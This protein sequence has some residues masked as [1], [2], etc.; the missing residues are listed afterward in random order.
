MNR[1]NS[2]GL[3]QPPP[4]GQRTFLVNTL[5]RGGCLNEFLNRRPS[6]TRTWR[7]SAASLGA[8]TS[9]C[10]AMVT[11]SSLIQTPALAQLCP[12]DPDHACDQ[13][14]GPGCTNLECCEAVCE[15][16][17][18]CCSQAWDLNCVAATEDPLVARACANTGPCSIP[19]CPGGASAENEACGASTNGGCNEAVPVFEPIAN[20]DTVCGTGWADGG[21]RDTDWF[22]ITL[23]DPDG[24]DIDLITVD[25]ISQFPS[26]VII[27]DASDCENIVAFVTNLADPCN[28]QTLAAL[29]PPGTYQI[30]IAPATDEG[31]LG[32]G[33]PC[34]GG[35]N[36]YQL[37]VTVEAGE[38]TCG[39]PGSGNCFE[40]TPGIPGCADENCCVTVCTVDPFCCGVEW[41]GQCVAEALDLCEIDF[42]VCGP[43][44]PNDCGAVNET[45][46]CSD[47]AC[48]TAVC[49]VDAFC[50]AVAWDA[51]CVTEAAQF[52]GAGPCVIECPEGGTFEADECGEDTNGGCN[53]EP[54]AFDPIANGDIICGNASA[55]GGTADL[56]WY[57]FEVADT[58]GNG[59][60]QVKFTV[61]SNFP[62]LFVIF[63]VTDCTN[64]IVMA[65]GD[66]ADCVTES[67]TANLPAGS[68]YAF[69]IRHGDLVDG[70]IFEGFPCGGANDY[71]FEYEVV[72][73]CTLTCPG[74]SVAEG[75]ACGANTNGGCNSTPNAFTN[76]VSGQTRCATTWAD[77][78][79][80]DTDW[81]RF[82]A[83]DSDGNGEAFA[84][85]TVAS[86][87]PLLVLVLP[88]GCPAG[89]PI[90]DFFVPNCDPVT[91]GLCVPAPAQYLIVA[92][93]GTEAGGIFE[94]FPCSS[95]I[96]DY[97]LQFT[98]ANSSP[99]CQPEACEE[100]SIVLS[101][102]GSQVSPGLGVACPAGDN[103]YARSYNLGTIAATAGQDVT[104]QCVQFGVET[105]T[106]ADRVCTV[107]VYADTN[108]GAP[109][110]SAPPG[111]DLQLLG[112]QN[113]LIESTDDFKVMTAN[114]DNPVEVPANTV[115]VVELFIPAQAGTIFPGSSED[116]QTGETFLLAPSCG[117]NDY[118]TTSSIGFPET[119]WIQN[120][121]VDVG[122]VGTPCPADLDDSGS[123]DG[124]DLGL[125]LSNWGSGG[126]GDL[127]GSGAVDGAD[128]GLLLAAWGV[129]PA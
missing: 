60:D 32:E 87:V 97:T 71:F 110:D 95:G 121:L 43:E 75:E 90:A 17:P 41:D 1:L 123:V 30:F 2:G 108:G 61:T 100:G 101:Q 106:G 33:F 107:N 21:N 86:E 13:A 122:A 118:V 54:P 53:V 91:I 22:E 15:F 42:S 116:P 56:D 74:G 82:T 46:G 78:A 70:P 62:S 18:S 105:N 31:G 10:A 127:D 12:P 65:A 51:V 55:S 23:T 14:G 19:P 8:R 92:I 84:T 9:A 49:E 112:S 113:V 36:D 6:V 103:F 45:P 109:V 102:T 48:C 81:Y 16:I 24:N 28:T 20:G 38:L 115:M 117:V 47:E 76:I 57:G 93:P 89:A 3:S 120:V 7:E 63:D 39:E 125:L 26:Q 69:L 4:D 64:P 29:L 80:R 44:N 27:L 5:R 129:C 40:A 73:Q 83:S 119:H 114:F 126:I 94:G 124:A 68:N 128:L 59:F 67:L 96:N 72:P 85:I 104:V 98:L 79:T 34:G 111:N 25:W 35:Q 52:C 99:E 58:D 37:S 66:A 11:I 50:C 88:N 77:A